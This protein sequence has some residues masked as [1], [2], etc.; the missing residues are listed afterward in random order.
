MNE[1]I[2]Q[3][4]EL[5]NLSAIFMGI[6]AGLLLISIIGFICVIVAAAFNA[7]NKNLTIFLIIAL[8]MCMLGSIVFLVLACIYQNQADLLKTQLDNIIP[9]LPI[10]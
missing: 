2:A 1:L 10:N 7:I 5:Q 9:I 8:T 6:C 4:T 3:I